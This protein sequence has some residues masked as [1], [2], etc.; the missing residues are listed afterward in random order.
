MTMIEVMM[1]AVPYMKQEYQKLK[2]QSKTKPSR[3]KTKHLYDMTKYTT[4]YTHP[5]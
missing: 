1:N 2:K 5:V 3:T 4:N